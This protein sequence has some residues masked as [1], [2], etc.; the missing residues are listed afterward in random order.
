M[1]WALRLSHG[2]EPRGGFECVA[3][4][5]PSRIVPVARALSPA[6]PLARNG[7]FLGSSVPRCARSVSPIGAPLLPLSD[8]CL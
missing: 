4:L 6:A 1:M 8:V 3:A 7:M 2:L 5:A